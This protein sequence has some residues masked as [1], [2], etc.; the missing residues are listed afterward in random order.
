MELTNSPI[1]NSGGVGDDDNDYDDLF[2]EEEDTGEEGNINIPRPAKKNKAETKKMSDDEL[3]LYIQELLEAQAMVSCGNVNCSCLE[4]LKENYGVRAVVANYLTG[5]ERKKL[6]NQDSII[7]DWYQF[8]EAMRFGRRQIWYCLPYDGTLCTDMGGVLNE[9]QTHKLCTK[10]L[11][12]VLNIGHN[13]FQSIRNASINGVI[14]PHKAVGK[15]SNHA[16]NDDD[17]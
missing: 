9:A 13:R 3:F 14:P 15:K 11:C 6:R 12:L 8:A 4:L 17:S 16:I 1:A 5:F 10:G 7:L 2:R